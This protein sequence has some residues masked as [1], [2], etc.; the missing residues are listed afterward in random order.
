MHNN[1]TPHK[2][3]PFMGFAFFRGTPAAPTPSPA[4]VLVGVAQ[5]GVAIPGKR[6]NYYGEMYAKALRDFARVLQN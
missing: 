5:Q 3:S 1:K 4:P 6:I 2:V